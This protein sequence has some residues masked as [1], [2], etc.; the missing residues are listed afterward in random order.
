MTLAR[1]ETGF[2]LRRVQPAAMLG[3]VVQREARPQGRAPLGAED[4]DHRPPA[5]QVQI[6][7]NQMNRLRRPIPPREPLQR[8]DEARRR[9]IRARVRQV[10][11]PLRLDDAVDIRRAPSDVF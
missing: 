7:H 5:V 6:V 10:P 1:P 11:P 2:D 8:L 4:A 9:P 3:R